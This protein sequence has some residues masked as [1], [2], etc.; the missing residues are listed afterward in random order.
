[1]VRGFDIPRE[2]LEAGWEAEE[3]RLTRALS[4]QRARAAWGNQWPEQLTSGVMFYE[5]QRITRKQ[6]EAKHGK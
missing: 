1:M 5:G 2:E 6:F 3:D 4:I